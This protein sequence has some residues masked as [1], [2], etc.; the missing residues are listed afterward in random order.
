MQALFELRNENIFHLANRDMQAM[1][2]IGK[3]NHILVRQFSY[4]SVR[5]YKNASHACVRNNG[6]ASHISV[7]K[8]SYFLI[9]KYRKARYILVG[10][11]RYFSVGNCE[12]KSQISCR[13]Y[14]DE[15]KNLI[16]SFSLHFHMSG[17][18]YFSVAFLSLKQKQI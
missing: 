12:H 2:M 17:T 9:K 14:L 16:G 13:N 18:L 7:R 5:N 11:S 8:S 15:R 1:F 3:L 4:L 6:N 10:K